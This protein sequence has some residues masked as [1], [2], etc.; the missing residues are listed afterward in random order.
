MGSKSKVKE[1]KTEGKVK[2][3]KRKGKEQQRDG[4][5][6]ERKSNDMETQRGGKNDDTD[7][8][9]NK[10]KEEQKEGKAKERKRKGK[11]I[12]TI[13]TKG[14]AT[15]CN[16]HIMKSKWQERTMIRK[17]GKINGRKRNGKERQCGRNLNGKGKQR[18]GIATDRKWK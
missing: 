12:M 15:E 7:V 2:G 8:R 16:T 10:G 3:R 14:H 18:K 4:K 13:R 5:A 9:N 6:K 11:E 17:E 1:N